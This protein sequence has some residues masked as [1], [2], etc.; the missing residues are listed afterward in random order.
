LVPILSTTLKRKI[1]KGKSTLFLGWARPH[2]SRHT[3][4]KFFWYQWTLWC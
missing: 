4:Q 2:Y 1:L 3:C